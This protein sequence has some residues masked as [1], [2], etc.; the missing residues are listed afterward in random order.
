MSNH[1]FIVYK[2]EIK[3]MVRD[4]RMLIAAFG[5][6]LL[7]PVMMGVLYL[8]SKDSEAE[9]RNTM[10]ALSNI[11]QAPGLVAFMEKREIDVV[12]FEGNIVPEELP[13]KADALLFLP[14][15]Y[16]EM[17]KQGKVVIGRL[18]VDENTKLGI[19][20]GREIGSAMDAYSS[21]VAGIRLLARGVPAA[22][23]SPIITSSYDL[24][25]A[26]FF[27]QFMGNMILM[28]MLMAPFVGGLVVAVDTLAGERERH[29]MQP[30]LAQP[31]TARSVIL[32]KL[33]MVSTFSI[34]SSLL[35]VTT[36][37]IAIS[38]IPAGTLPFAV[39]VNAHTVPLIFIQL[40]PFSILIAATQLFISIQ[41][42]SYK[43]GQSYI[44][45]FMMVPMFVSYLKIFGGEKLADFALFAPILAEME[46]LGSLFFT[47]EVSVSHMTSSILVS[48]IGILVLTWFTSRKLQSEVMLD[49]A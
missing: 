23:A 17:I 10:L 5:F 43:E 37:L 42:K 6:A 35:S 3:D 15:N 7:M 24:G 19:Q 11:H 13:G 4:R 33:A 28:M 48:I 21:Y 38:F 1:A 22:V 9:A 30:L 26:G 14:D 31:V 46:S 20:R 45:M 41:V 36:L 27:R 16:G 34:V 40:I 49:A 32:G 29:S 39:Y 25:N 47:G 18:Y 44:S 12:E 2:K 8:V